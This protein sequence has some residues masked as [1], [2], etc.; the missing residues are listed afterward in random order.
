[1]L[2]AGIHAL[3]AGSPPGT[4]GDDVTLNMEKYCPCTSNRSYKSCCQP[5][6]DGD[7][8][9]SSAEQLMCSRYS[10]FCLGNINY[11]IA[12]LHPDKRKVD[13]EQALDKTIKQTKWLGLRV[14]K[15]KQSGQT[16]TVEFVAF[17]KNEP[18][19]Q[20]HE[21]SNFIKEGARW[22]YVD[23]EFLAPIKLA[24]NELCFCGSGKKFKKCHGV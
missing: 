13:D 6:H 14:I 15:H 22:F 21:R 20:L 5:L 24:R 3:K 18:I 16:A 11:L 1:M 7:L 17:F 12:T 23:G 8:Q 10:A 9:A 2:L 19:G 4:S